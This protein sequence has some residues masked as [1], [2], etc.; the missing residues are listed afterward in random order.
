MHTTEEEEEALT[1]SRLEPS[2]N[3]T[4]L[5]PLHHYS[6]LSHRPNFPKILAR[7]HPSSEAART[8]RTTIALFW[9]QMGLEEALAASQWKACSSMDGPL[10]A[11]VGGGRATKT[12]DHEPHSQVNIVSF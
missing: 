10:L 3:S 9:R 2:P 12:L 1:S 11:S 4:Y 8:T 6:I 5:D 7:L